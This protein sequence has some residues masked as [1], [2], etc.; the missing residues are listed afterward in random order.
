MK[1]AFLAPVR[2]FAFIVSLLLPLGAWA[3]QVVFIVEGQ[4]NEA[5]F[6]Y[7]TG[8]PFQFNFFLN[9]YAPAPPAGSISSDTSGGGAVGW[10]DNAPGVPQVWSAITGTGLTGSWTPTITSA[11][12]VAINISGGP[13]TTSSLS[14]YANSGTGMQ[15]NGFTLTDL[16]VGNVYE[17]FFITLPNPL[18][19]QFPPGGLDPTQFFLG[20]LGTYHRDV[21]FSP[22]GRIYAIGSNGGG[23]VNFTANTLTIAAIVPEPET[24]AM[25][26]TGLGLVSWIMR[27]RLPAHGLSAI[28]GNQMRQVRIE[29]A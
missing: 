28:C 3:Q 7:T 29:F 21:Q 14:L 8:Q 2:A 13:V 6:G 19:I 16:Q 9:N 5:G 17:N 22:Y 25:L 23:Q 26:L 15:T 4:F 20:H 12:Q 1:N 18:N 24:W 11:S 27:R 10:I